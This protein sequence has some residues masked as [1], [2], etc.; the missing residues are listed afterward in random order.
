MAD[1]PATPVPSA[2]LILLRDG[3]AGLEVLMLKRHADA[4]FSG[5]LVFPGGRVDPG[6]AAPALHARCRAPA[7][8]DRAA[9]AERVAALRE[10]YE[11][12]NLLLACRRGEHAPL[13]AAAVQ[14]LE[15]EHASR[16]G[17]AAQVADLVMDG[18]VELAA[19]AL[20]PFGRW[21]TPERSPRRFDAMFFVARAPE[22][23]YARPDGRET[24]AATWSAPAAFLAE[25]DAA[26]ERLVFA[27]RMNLVR[28]AKY[29]DVATALA[30][31]AEAASRIVPICPEIYR[32]PDGLRI[33]IPPGRGTALGYDDCDMPAAD[34]EM[35]RPAPR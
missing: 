12:A 18:G 15:A 28:L 30:A 23:Q 32:A 27:T 13:T 35:P 34:R 8:A 9:L 21:V 10:C 7:G 11:E 14:A 3:T 26:R 1:A 29:R 25:A 17:R 16:L 20:V 31:A 19:D 22:E 24:V 5:A 33:R 6:D 2:T 4:V